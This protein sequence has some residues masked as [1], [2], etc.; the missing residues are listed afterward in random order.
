MT[1][2]LTMESTAQREVIDILCPVELMKGQLALETRL[3]TT[4]NYV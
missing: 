2:T 4:I 1:S 3:L